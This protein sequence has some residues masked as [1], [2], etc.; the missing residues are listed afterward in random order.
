MMMREENRRT[1]RKTCPSATLFTKNPAANR[2]SQDTACRAL[3]NVVMNLL[4][5]QKAGKLLD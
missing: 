3:K 4:I 5:Q 2:L 1:W